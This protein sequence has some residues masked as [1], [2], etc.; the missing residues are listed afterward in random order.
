MTTSDAP[1]APG[2]R[3]PW[4]FRVVVAALASTLA[5]GGLEAI[6]AAADLP[7]GDALSAES[8]AEASAVVDARVYDIDPL[9][10]WRMH[11][12][13][14]LDAPDLGFVHVRTNSR[15][16]RGEDRGD[17]LKKSK[18]RVLCLGDSITFGVALADDDAYPS[19]L[20]RA[21]RALLPADVAPVVVNGGV[22][23][24]SSIQGARL[25]DELAPLSP[26]VI[27]WWFGM[28]DGKP[29]LGDPDSKLRPPS[30][31]DDGGGVL[32][33]LRR[34]RTVRFARSLGA[35]LRGA[36]TRV[37]TDEV[38]AEVASLAARA[39]AGGPTTIFVRCP[40]RLDEKLAQLE[41]IASVVRAC[42]AKRVEG[43]TDALSEY[44][45]G[46]PGCDSAVRVDD[47]AGGR[48]AVL[49]AGRLARVVIDVDEVVRRRDFVAKWKSAVDAYCAAMP[50]DALGYADL[51][52]AR[53][54]A[55]AFSDNCH[56]T[57]ASA[58]VAADSLAARIVDVYA[59]RAA[60][61]G[62]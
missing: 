32:G 25:L 15:G 60:S 21:L 62:R 44:V 31:S 48:V 3:R 43:S 42:G 36:A 11:R 47:A 49:G 50:A 33:A 29:A 40:S 41:S 10:F 2:V 20:E 57:A 24:Y 17:D 45:P 30:A 5:V 53:T 35:G 28:N 9:L 46:P 23:G 7:R 51:F 38:R 12:S 14:V 59:K 1:A 39:A 52:G 19:R 8:T 13:A 58:R 26:D 22:P 27:V 37:S 18:L 6:L 55:D 4:T 34:L 16:L 54:P 61:R 56:M